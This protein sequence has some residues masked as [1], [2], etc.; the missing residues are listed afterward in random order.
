MAYK[1]TD[2]EK[3]A[4][5]MMKKLLKKPKTLKASDFK[6]G[7]MILYTYR[8]KYK[9][10]PY[11]MSPMCMVL[12][13]SRKYTLGLNMNWCPPKLRKGLMDYIM[14][15]NKTNIRKGLPLEL[16]Y[17]MVKT[18]IKGLGPIVRLYINRRISP[19]GV[20]VPQ[21]QY[22]KIIDLRAE[23]F[24]GISAEKAWN[25]AVKEHIRKKKNR[26]SKGNRKG[27]KGKR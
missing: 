7:N 16:S 4:H 27:K 25:L 21:N 2:K 23:N 11:D 3:E 1:L 6:P 26:K 13:R 15:K 14:R 5:I 9:E 19:K 17:D 10:N 22:Y 12:S 8:P 20:V 24:I 18:V